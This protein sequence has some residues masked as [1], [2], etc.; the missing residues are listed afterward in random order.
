MRLEIR[1]GFEIHIYE[2]AAFDKRD[3]LLMSL[4]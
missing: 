3:K 1:D 2:K 4:Q